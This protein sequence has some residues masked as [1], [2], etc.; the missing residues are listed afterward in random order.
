MISMPNIMEHW[1]R[2]LILKF[3]WWVIVQRMRDWYSVFLMELFRLCRCS[4][5]HCVTTRP[6]RPRWYSN[7]RRCCNPSAWYI[8]EKGTLKCN[9]SHGF[10]LVYAVWTTNMK[11]TL[12]AVNIAGRSNAAK[13]V[14]S[15]SCEFTLFIHSAIGWKLLQPTACARK[16]HTNFQSYHYDIRMHFLINLY[17]IS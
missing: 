2:L 15:D 10:L 13:V 16:I 5:G 14:I 8:S 6:C 11:D 3:V 12:Q 4:S 7:W 1:A 17:N 9:G